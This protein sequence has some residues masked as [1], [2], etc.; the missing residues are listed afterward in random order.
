[1]LGRKVPTYPAYVRG[2]SEGPPVE[3]PCAV[4]LNF[5]PWNPIKPWNVALDWF[6][7]LCTV[8]GRGSVYPIAWQGVNEEDAGNTFGHWVIQ[9]LARIDFNFDWE[10]C[11]FTF[12]PDAIT[13][14]VPALVENL[15]I[16]RSLDRMAIV[17]PP[18]P[19]GY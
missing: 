6:L 5:P 7:M 13:G 10:R 18:R 8:A 12:R 9:P 19:S 14:Y 1:M 4:P 2:S 15:S 16:R 17:N 3:R 11:P